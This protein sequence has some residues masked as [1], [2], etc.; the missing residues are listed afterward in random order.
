[1]F[2]G[3]LLFFVFLFI[4]RYLTGE[5]AI[6]R[7]SNGIKKKKATKAKMAIEYVNKNVHSANQ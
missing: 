3:F 1:M 7:K 5:P 4:G 6:N 2:Y